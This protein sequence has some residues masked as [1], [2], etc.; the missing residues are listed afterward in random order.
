[1]KSALPPS[2]P[3]RISDQQPAVDI[4]QEQFR[5]LLRKTDQYINER[6]FDDA[7]ISLEEAKSIDP[8]NP[9]IAAFADRIRLFESNPNAKTA[10]QHPASPAP[11]KQT[12]PPPKAPPPKIEQPQISR[13]VLDQRLRQQIEAEYKNKYMQELRKAEAA[14]AKHL[15]E[16]RQKLEQQRH[17]LKIQ[18]EH[19][20][21]EIQKRLEQEHQQK[22]DEEIE[23]AEARLRQQFQKEQSFVEIELKT[24]LATHHEEQLRQLEDKLK[25]DQLKLVEG[26]RESFAVREKKMKEEFNHKLLDSL[27]KTERMFREQTIQEQKLEQEKLRQQ[28]SGEFETTLSK[29]REALREQYETQKKKLEQSFTEERQ[30]LTAEHQGMLNSQM[31]ALRVKDAEAFEKK[32]I[33][34]HSDIESEFQKKYEDQLTIERKRL[35]DE[36]NRAIEEEKKRL[37][38]EYDAMISDHNKKVQE[39]RNE[40]RKEMEQTFISRLQQVAHEFDHKM[41]LLGTKMPQTI[42]EKKELYRERLQECYST[43]QPSE[44][45]AKRLMELKELL[46]LSFDNHLEIE[47]DV[48]LNRYAEL[49]KKQILAG[50]LNLNDTEKLRAL[51]NEFRISTEEAARLEPYLLSSFQRLAVKGRI[52]LADDEP[53][54]L[55]SV[56]DLLTDCGFQ[57]VTALSVKIALEKLT[58][59]AIDIIVSDIKY[60]PDEMDGFGFFKLVQEQP[61]LRSIPFVFMSSMKDAVFVRSGMQL[62][63]DDYLTKP[64]D[65]EMLI[66]VIEG[67]LKRYRNVNQN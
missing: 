16:E 38:V 6:N 42:E 41:E 15:E 3:S 53:L 35:L 19:Q 20:I 18:F 49:V 43:G 64:V 58:E 65:P 12:V 31:E 11:L 59:A 1:M 45:E 48:R 39:V 26:D 61:H 55:E 13:E 62:G 56:G 37:Q 52:L 33:Q 9:Y 54:L 51:K 14:A 47:A 28:L 30:K 57:V 46:E 4:N 25:Q 8:T 40:M 27:R 34:L 32:R 7:K 23:A 60:A 29:E 5:Q 21:D 63:V 2:P 44:T 36:S 22:V 24:R 66:A 50:T 67:K 10:A 17:L